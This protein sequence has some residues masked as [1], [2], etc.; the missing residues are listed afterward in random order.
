MKRTPKEFS[1]YLTDMIDYADKASNFLHGISL[2]SFKANE[3]KALAVIRSLEVIGEAARKIPKPVRDKYPQVPWA[4]I[5]GM[6]DK[7]IHD[8]FGVSLDVVW[9]TVKNDL[10]EMSKALRIMMADIT[11]RSN[12]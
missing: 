12:P 2:K 1:G 4:E 6:R 3:E 11:A 8:Y 9:L 10:P 7:L 5:T